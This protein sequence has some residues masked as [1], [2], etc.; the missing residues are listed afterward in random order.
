[1][2][3]AVLFIAGLLLGA[4]ARPVPVAAL[5]SA[6]PSHVQDAAEL[7]DKTVA[8]VTKDDEGETRAYCSGV[9]VSPTSILTAAHCVADVVQDLEPVGYVVRADVY[10]PGSIAEREAV[11]THAA[12]VYARD[13]NHD[14]A[15]L[16][17]ASAP[18]HLTALL[19]KRAIEPGA[20]VQAMGHSIGLWWSYSTGE[21]SAVRS[22]DIGIGASDF[23]WIQA[24]TPISPGNSGGGLFDA[25]GSLIGITTASFR[26]GQLLNVF[27][28]RM[29]IEAFLREQTARTSL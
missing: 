15:L 16:R 12:L 25:E 14:L 8:L 28:H 10:S 3:S 29:H 18:P 23:T 4:C 11:P 13:E 5:P 2:R 6:P 19:T 1:M 22:K 20:F 9:W 17:G 26:R 24:N 7:T 27:V 21:I